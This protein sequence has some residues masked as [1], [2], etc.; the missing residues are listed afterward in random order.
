M[1]KSLTILIFLLV[2]SLLH[3]QGSSLE[4]SHV[5]WQYIPSGSTTQIIVPSEHVLK[6]TQ[7]L[8]GG[9]NGTY[10]YIYY[11]S[12]RI[13]HAG[14]TSRALESPIWLPTGTY[15]F[16]STDHGYISGIVFKVVQ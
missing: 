9:S 7:V 6:I 10:D 2:S 8:A 5:I 13:A 16:G 14:P 15:G 4:F 3:A 11:G 1:K 12:T